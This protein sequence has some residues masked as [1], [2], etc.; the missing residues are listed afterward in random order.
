MLVFVNTLFQSFLT[1][2]RVLLWL[3]ILSAA[4]CSASDGGGGGGNPKGRRR[5][6]LRRTARQ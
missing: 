6:E 1:P 3:A 4:A 2:V 5:K